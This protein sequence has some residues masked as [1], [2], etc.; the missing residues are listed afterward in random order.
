MTPY[1]NRKRSLPE[2]RKVKVKTQNYLIL[3]QRQRDVEGPRVCHTD[4]K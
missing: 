2:E 1:F 3:K 4:V